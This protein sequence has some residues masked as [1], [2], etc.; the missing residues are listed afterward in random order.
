MRPSLILGSSSPR[1]RQLL[2]ALQLKFGVVKPLTEERPRPGED[3]LTY[4]LRNAAEKA[5][6]TAAQFRLGKLDTQLVDGHEQAI[7]LSAD[8]IVVL[9]GAIIEKPLDTHDARQILA[10]LSGRTHTVISGVTLLQV[11]RK[12]TE[13]ISEQFAVET[14]VWFRQ[15]TPSDI[16]AYV[17]TG[18]PMDKAGAYAMQGQGSFLVTR[19]EG[20][21]SNVIGL[22]VAEV[23]E[24]LAS[25]FAYSIWREARN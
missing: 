3:A 20:S 16:A 19:I 6:W 13:T 22:P 11:E 1:R 15:L 12:R 24:K 17:A 10:R 23:V 18:E 2:E 4:A 5:E 14:K 21:Y 7:I 8:T 9:D 25:R